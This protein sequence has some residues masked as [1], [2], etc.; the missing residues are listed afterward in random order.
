MPARAI[1]PD[2]ST[3]LR[4]SSKVSLIAAQIS[5]VFTVTIAGSTIGPELSDLRRRIISN[6]KAPICA[7]AVPSAN[8]P[9]CGKITRSFAS[10]AAFKHADSSYSTPIIFT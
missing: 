2:G 4:F 7:T 10:K 5:S 1:A 3:M 9:T 8:K 6:G